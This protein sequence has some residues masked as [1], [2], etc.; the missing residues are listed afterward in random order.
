MLFRS[1]DRPN[2]YAENDLDVTGIGQLP[3]NGRGT[4]ICC[5]AS[6]FENRSELH[7]WEFA[8]PLCNAWGALSTDTLNGPRPPRGLTRRIRAAR[9]GW[10]Y[11]GMSILDAQGRSRVIRRLRYQLVFVWLEGFVPPSGWQPWTMPTS[12]DAPLARHLAG[13]LRTDA[14]QEVSTWPPSSG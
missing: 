2:S 5:V 3:R 4:H 1:P 6:I 7:A 8:N 12:G 14:P 9:A 13:H 10:L 11:V